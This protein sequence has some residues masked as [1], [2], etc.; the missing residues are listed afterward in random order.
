MQPTWQDPAQTLE[1]ELLQIVKAL[2]RQRGFGR[3]RMLP[4]CG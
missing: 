4:M 3:C 2:E 1:G